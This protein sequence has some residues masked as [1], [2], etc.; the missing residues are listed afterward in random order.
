MMH[1]LSTQ[2]SYKIRTEH[3]NYQSMHA[4]QHGSESFATK[5]S[6]HINWHIIGWLLESNLQKIVWCD[7]QTIIKTGLI[8]G[9]QTS[10]SRLH[11]FNTVLD[12]FC[13]WCTWQ[14]GWLVSWLAVQISKG[15]HGWLVSW[16]WNNG[17]GR[18]MG[19]S[20]MHSARWLAG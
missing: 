14:T 15:F 6:L 3:D 1:A 16:L 5:T 17:K 19:L 11:L 20:W 9:G 2:A 7:M 13:W 8:E 12:V 10:E 4:I 18:G